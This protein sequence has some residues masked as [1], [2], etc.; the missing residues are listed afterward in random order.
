MDD[1][2]FSWDDAK[3]E[4]NFEKHKLSF[5]L[6]RRIFADDDR[7]EDFDGDSS[8]G[9]DRYFCI[10]AIDFDVYYISYAVLEDGRPRIISVRTA[11][12]RE[13]NG[14]YNRKATR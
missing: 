2:E 4:K 14:Y 7:W 3:A 13:I 10:G 6:V 1:D 12:K 9:E 8:Y 11:S 5:H